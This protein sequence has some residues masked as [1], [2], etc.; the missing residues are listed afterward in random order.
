MSND[1]I[2]IRG[3]PGSGKSTL[4]TILCENGKC[5]V[6][7]VDRFFTDPSGKYTFDH[8]KNHLAYKACETNTEKDMRAGLEK[9]FVDNTFT[10]DWEIEPYFKLAAKYGYRVFVI[11]VENHHGGENIHGVTADQLKKMA[12]KYKVKLY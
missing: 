5:P 10:I 9:I 2:L 4:A 12:E 1:L 11:T 6:H 7:S 8:S 3:L